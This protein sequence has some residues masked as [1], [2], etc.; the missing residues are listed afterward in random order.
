MTD[1]RVLLSKWSSEA[2]YVY[3]LPRMRLSRFIRTISGH[4]AL[5]YFQSKIDPEVDPRCRLCR[6]SDETF[7]HLVT[8]CPRLHRLRQDK[9]LDMRISNDH[10]WS[11]QELIEF[12]LNPK[13]NKMFEGLNLV[14][15][16]IYDNNGNSDESDVTTDE[17]EDAV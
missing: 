7:F 13:V 6:Q 10:G 16:P 3:K 2:K 17:F 12:S 8:E 4:N 1:R 5:M 15:R 11:V 14:K 9:F